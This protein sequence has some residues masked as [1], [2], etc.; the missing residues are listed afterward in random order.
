MLKIIT[1]CPTC[2]SLLE[3]VN[4]Q[5]FCRN[6]SC[7][8]QTF[9]KLEHFAKVMKIK[10]LGEK[11]LEK[12]PIAEIWELY[13]FTQRELEE[14]LGAKIGAKI[15]SEIENSATADLATIL[16]SFSIPLVGETAA[17]KLCSVVLDINE[18]TAETCAKAGLGE[19][20]AN[21]LLTFLAENQELLSRLPFTFKSNATAK[22]PGGLFC[23]TVVITGKLKNYSSRALAKSFLEERGF[24][25]AD[26]VTKNTDYLI[27]DEGVPSSKRT[28]AES[29]N[30]QVVTFEELINKENY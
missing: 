25:V 3:R 7:E 12:L 27:D 17:K 18:I 11:T 6:K 22:I 5:L 19:K 9:K 21:N 2:D 28:K 29:Y 14:F 13:E 30:I 8:A 16:Q 10:G 15:A 4:N 23:K 24:V 1:N 20:A 26:S